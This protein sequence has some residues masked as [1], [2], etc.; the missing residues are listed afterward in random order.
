MPPHHDE[1]NIPRL[2]GLYAK[3]SGMRAVYSKPVIQPAEDVARKMLDTYSE[4]GKSFVELHEMATNG[5]IDLLQGFS[6]ACR[7]EFEKMQAKQF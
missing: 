7:D 2:V 1:A 3:L 4:P 6:D 5:A